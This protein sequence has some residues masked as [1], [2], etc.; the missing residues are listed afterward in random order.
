MLMVLPKYDGWITENTERQTVGQTSIVDQCMA[1][2]FV[3]AQSLVFD[4][5]SKVNGW[6]DGWMDGRTNGRM[7]GHSLIDMLG[8]IK[9]EKENLLLA[10]TCVWQMD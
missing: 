7:D 6:T 3:P 8:G 10:E 9:K 4:R 5:F 1:S 2:M